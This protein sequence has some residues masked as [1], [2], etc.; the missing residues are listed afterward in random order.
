DKKIF[1]KN[2]VNGRTVYQREI[3]PNLEVGKTTNLEKMQKGNAPFV[4]KNGKL[5][6]VELHHSRQNNNASLFETSQSTHRKTATEKGSEALHPYK[7]ERGREINNVDITKTGKEHPINP[8]DRSAFNKE[9]VQYW[10]QRASDF[11]KGE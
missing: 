1:T 11:F 2:E 4:D 9:R 5:E 7:T 10:K 6:S 3:D 8:V